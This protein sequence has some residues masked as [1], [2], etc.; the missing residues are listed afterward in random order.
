MLENCLLELNLMV[1]DYLARHYM[2]HYQRACNEVI[3]S[4][5]IKLNDVFDE[6]TVQDVVDWI[7]ENCGIDDVFNSISDRDIINYVTNECSM[8]DVLDGY[9]TQDVREWISDNYD[10]EDIVC[11]RSY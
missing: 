3:E 9:C 10:V 7:D 1:A 5:E 6:Y 11:W 2:L 4:G 8:G